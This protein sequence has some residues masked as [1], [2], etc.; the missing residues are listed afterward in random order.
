MTGKKRIDVEALLARVDIVDVISRYVELRK[1]GAEFEACCPFHTESTPSFKVSPAKQIYHCFGCGA[2]GNAIGFL[3]AHQGMDFLEACAALG[4]D[5]LPQGEAPTP[6][7]AREKARS[8]WVATLD[9][10]ADPPA[11][12]VA[13]YARGRPQRVW[14]YRSATGAVLGYVYRFVTSDG[15]KEVLPVVW[16]TNADTGGAEWRFMAFPEPRPL[17]GLDRLAAKP[18]AS[19]LIVEGEKCAD[20]GHDELPELAVLSWPGGGKADRKSVV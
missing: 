5:A 3:I 20:A 16:A 8:P 10:P 17:Y 11:P 2:D 4:A 12:P 6:A 1:A 9:V 18:D 14:V 13:H 15:G 7:P 19:V